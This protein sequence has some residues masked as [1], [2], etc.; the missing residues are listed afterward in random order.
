[1]LGELFPVKRLTVIWGVCGRWYPSALSHCFWLCYSM[2]LDLLSPYQKG[3]TN[4]DF[5]EARDTEW[6]WHQLGYSASPQHPLLIFGHSLPSTFILVFMNNWSV[7]FVIPHLV[8]GINSLLLSDCHMLTAPSQTLIC[9]RLSLQLSPQIHHSHY[10]NSF[11]LPLSA[12]N[13]PL[14]QIL[15]TIDPLFVSQTDLMDSWLF[16]HFFWAYL[17]VFGSMR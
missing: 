15:P 2:T 5:T 6:K 1:M 16:H 4:L 7:V 14:W 10:P 8:S 17:V 13:L 11:T 3:K 9:L 12:Q